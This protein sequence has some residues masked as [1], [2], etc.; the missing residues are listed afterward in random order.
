MRVFVDSFRKK[1]VDET[2]NG[3][4]ILTHAHTDHSGSLSQNCKHQIHCSPVTKLLMGPF[5]P[6]VDFEADLICDAWTVVDQTVLVYCFY[7]Q[8]CIGG[9]GIYCPDLNLLHF[10]DGRP[11]IKTIDKILQFHKKY[12]N[13]HTLPQNVVCDSYIENIVQKF[14]LEVSNLPQIPTV[15]ESSSVI[16]QLLKKLLLQGEEIE[17]QVT[18]FGAISALPRV[19]GYTWF[20]P[21]LAQQQQAHVLCQTAFRTFQFTEGPIVVSYAWAIR[22][23]LSKNEIARCKNKAVIILSANWFFEQEERHNKL[24]EPQVD[25]HGYIR[26]FVCSH[27]SPHELSFNFRGLCIKKEP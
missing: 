24:L 19:F 7:S 26:V 1:D 20:Q 10:G 23:R 9:I 5:Y 14:N 8:H 18:H 6:L 22:P 25:S 4:Y 12:V 13:Q 2:G 21:A 15:S 27:A 16:E 17:I 3:I 11:R